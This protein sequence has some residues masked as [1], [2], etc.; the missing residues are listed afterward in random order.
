MF[1]VTYKLTKTEIND[2]KNEISPI[3]SNNNGYKHFN[4]FKVK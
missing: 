4:I 3:S 1:L 2:N